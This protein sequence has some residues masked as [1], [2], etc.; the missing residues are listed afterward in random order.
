MKKKLKKRSGVKASGSGQSS[1]NNTDNI[2]NDQ[3]VRLEEYSK[4]RNMLIDYDTIKEDLYQ[5]LLEESYKKTSREISMY[6]VD[7]REFSLEDIESLSKIINKR[8][9]KVNLIAVRCIDFT[10]LTLFALCVTGEVYFPKDTDI[11]M[12]SINPIPKNVLKRISKKISKR[13]GVKAKVISKF[14]N[15][16]AIVNPWD[17][18]IE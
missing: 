15:D 5:D 18:F 3:P 13:I 12:E 8:K 4:P 11:H 6:V 2:N 16:K 1:E 7:A 17:L 14:Y 10:E 9:L